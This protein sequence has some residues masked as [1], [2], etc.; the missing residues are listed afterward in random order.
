[1]ILGPRS[2]IK[3]ILAKDYPKVLFEML[4]KRCAAESL[5]SKRGIQIHEVRSSGDVWMRNVSN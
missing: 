5:H 3:N 4:F 2:P 1:M